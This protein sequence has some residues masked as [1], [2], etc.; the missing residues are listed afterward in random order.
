MKG[1]LQFLLY[2]MTCFYFYGNLNF[3]VGLK[4]M[5]FIFS[6]RGFERKASQQSLGAPPTY[7]EAVN[8]NGTPIHVSEE[9]LV[10]QLLRN[11]TCIFT[12]A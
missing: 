11:F 4:Q 9:R 7:E 10:S 1:S 2:V 5:Q 3:V 12:L 6:Y 8:G